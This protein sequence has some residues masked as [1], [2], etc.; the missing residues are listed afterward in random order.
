M[1]IDWPVA[2]II[3]VLIAAGAGVLSGILNHPHDVALKTVSEKYASQYQAL[4]Q[5]TR[6]LQKAI[7]TDLADIR[8]KVESIERMMREVG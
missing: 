3:M 8:T 7:Q 2:L 6:D 1:T 5:E 4:A